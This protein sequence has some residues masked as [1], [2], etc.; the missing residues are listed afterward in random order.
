MSLR[1]YC[2]RTYLRPFTGVSK[3]SETVA[4]GGVLLVKFDAGVLAS[5]AATSPLTGTLDMPDGMT[6]T[7][8]ALTGIPDRVGVLGFSTIRPSAALLD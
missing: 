7:P 1:E 8:T 6:D 3:E 2:Y 5:T 4:N